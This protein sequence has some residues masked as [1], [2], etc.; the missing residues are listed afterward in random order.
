MERI[1]EKRISKGGGKD[2]KSTAQSFYYQIIGKNSYLAGHYP[3]R[4]SD[5]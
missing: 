3:W 2:S 4:R 1:Q 5:Q